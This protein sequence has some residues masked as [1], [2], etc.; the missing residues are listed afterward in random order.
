M[1]ARAAALC[2]RLLP[3]GKPAP[4]PTPVSRPHTQ[5]RNARPGKIPRGQESG[6]PHLAAESRSGGQEDLAAGVT[7]FK[8]IT[9]R[10][11]ACEG[12]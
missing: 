2:T 11:L 7:G 12:E 10:G 8:G 1:P 3:N 9:W 6:P 4:S 5:P